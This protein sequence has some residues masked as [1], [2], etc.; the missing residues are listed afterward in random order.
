[1]M[2]SNE[3]VLKTILNRYPAPYQKSLELF[4]PQDER[5]RLEAMPSSGV[6][7]DI[8]EQPLLKRVHWSWLLP[9]LKTL[10]LQEQKLFLNA[11]PSQSKEHLHHELNIKML[12]REPLARIVQ[13][14]VMQTLEERLIGESLQ[15][16]PVYFLPP[17]PLTPLLHLNKQQFV[18]LI[19]FLSLNDLATE[20]MQI[21]E[22]KIL[23]KIYSFL[24]EEEKKFLKKA[25][26]IKQPFS[27][28]RLPLKKW[29]GTE[30][31]FRHLLHRRG[32][33]RLGIA[34]TAEHPDFI[35]YIC[36]Q[37]DIG[38]GR[39]LEKFSKSEL[40]RGT[41]PPIA[42]QIEKLLKEIA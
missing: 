37:L 13:E 24:S 4:L 29:D 36:R 5:I 35:W 1:M 15:L 27:L 38:R 34:L 18:Q 16:L 12:P 25:A 30:K 11:L 28:P 31:S 39:A 17:S 7:T 40:A 10:T 20:L 14:F 42:H 3:W 26:H 41:S 19:D 33:A 23:K 6:D 21:V 22:T 9:I 32:L 2:N 8:E